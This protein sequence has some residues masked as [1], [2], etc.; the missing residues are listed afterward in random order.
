VTTSR[1]KAVQ[2][3]QD[4]TGR[5][6]TAR[7]RL[8]LAFAAATA[9]LVACFATSASPIP[10]YP[11]YRAEDGLTSA[12]LSLS[13]VA[14]FVGTIT[15]LL[16]LGRLSNH[17]G[18]RP[19][20]VATLVLLAAG[21]AVL[22]DVD[23]VVTLA[24]GRLLMGVG[25]GLASST[26]TAFVVDAA[27]PRPSWLGSVVSSQA[28]MLGLTV[29]AIGSGALVELAPWPRAL[30]FVVAIALL[31]VCVGLVALSPETAQAAPGARASLRPRVEVPRRA[32]PLLPVAAV[33][34]LA[35]W[36][37]GAYYQ[38]FVPTLT[39]DQLGSSDALLVGLVFSAYMAPSVIGAPL[40]ARLT[41]AIGQRI[42]MTVFLLGIAA[43]LISLRADSFALLVAASAVAGAGQGVAVSATI[44]VLLHGSTPA[45][46]SPLFAAVYLISYSGAAVPSLVSGQLSHSLTLVEITVGYALLAAL[47]TLVTL[48][49]S[50]DPSD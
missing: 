41:P 3:S 12:D 43:L 13:V 49:R 19:V 1:T 38:A 11:T 39:V 8:G 36:A 10:L 17:L 15:A 29:G 2:T 40:G 22:L 16:V 14:Y 5:T 33:V 45:E 24:L 32:R 48:V 6:T 28:P 20:A 26:L 23:G 27:P 9:S 35:T 21:A 47:A 50:R 42:G 34:L 37:T 44:R 18:R 7:P 31:V 46:R 4:S 30:V 25:A